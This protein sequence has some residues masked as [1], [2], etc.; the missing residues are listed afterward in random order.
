MNRYHRLRDTRKEGGI[1]MSVSISAHSAEEADEIFE[2]RWRQRTGTKVPA[3]FTLT[4][5]ALELIR[6][7]PTLDKHL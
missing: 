7:R 1:R 4:P 3:K 5:A 2:E 6:N